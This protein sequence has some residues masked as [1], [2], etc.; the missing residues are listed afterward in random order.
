MQ[1]KFGLVA[2][3]GQYPIVVAKALQRQDYQ[4]YCLGIRGH[5]DSK[6]KEI[7]DDYREVG[8]CRAGTQVRYFQR[9]GIHKATMAGKLFKTLLFERFYL[10]RHL[11]D[12]TCL[13]YIYPHLISGTKDN[14]DDSLMLTAIKLYADFGIHFAPATNFAPELLV[15]EGALTRRK[16]SSKEQIDIAF[17]WNLAKEMGRLD[18][19]QSVSI[20]RSAVLAVEAVEGTDE[21]IRRAGKLCKSG[22]FTVVKVAKPG[23]DMRFD[24]PAIGVGTL[25][26][27]I[28]S[29][30]NTLAIE[31]DKTIIIH[32]AEVVQFANDNNLCIVAVQAEA[33]EKLAAA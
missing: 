24:V 11:P 20:K 1:K 9:N 10:I 31:A 32:E 16:P 19:G 17:G 2:G 33:M 26:T 7:C 28:E 6:L 12:W 15:K 21:S 14:K 13:R 27:M 5:A 29:G 8:I 25:K 18:V 30:A 3:W 23:Q 22:G 4:V